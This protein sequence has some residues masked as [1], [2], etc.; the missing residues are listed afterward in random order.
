MIFCT[1]TLQRYAAT[2]SSGYV[3]DSLLLN[4][5]KYKYSYYLNKLAFGDMCSHQLHT[6]NWY[7]TTERKFKITHCKLYI[8]KNERNVLSVAT[9]YKV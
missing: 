2:S 9:I 4:K 5:Y 7:H 6:Y 3:T 1:L 8:E